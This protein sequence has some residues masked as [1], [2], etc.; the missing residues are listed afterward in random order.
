M[1]GRVSTAPVDNA[2]ACCMLE[3]WDE[4][5]LTMTDLQ[6]ILQA[7]DRLND[8][9]REQQRAYLDRPVEYPP[10]TDEDTETKIARLHEA[11]AEIRAGMT[12]EELDEM[13][14][15][16]NSEYIEPFDPADYT[17]LDDNEDSSN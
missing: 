9:E 17:W 8:E 13:I 1:R 3:M 2:A 12:Q 4:E 11:F 15:V 6:E 14:E 5:L 16:M 7:I 10:I